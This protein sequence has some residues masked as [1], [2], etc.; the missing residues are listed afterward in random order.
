MENQLSQHNLSVKSPFPAW[1]VMSL[2]QKRL[3]VILC[4]LLVV[5]TWQDSWMLTLG[6]A[7][8]SAEWEQA[9]ATVQLTRAHLAAQ[10]S[11][12]E[13]NMS[14]SQHQ[15][16]FVALVL[17]LFSKQLC[18]PTIKFPHIKCTGW[19]LM[20]WQTCTLLDQT[21]QPNNTEHVHLSRKFPWG[22][23]Q[24]TSPPLPPEATTIIW[25]H[26]CVA[27]W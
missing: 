27:H 16:I 4:I 8:M 13:M 2:C 18:L 12:P 1:L 10:N 7:E 6:A 15:L 26:T 23:L 3:S 17:M 25:N 20:T 24:S 11:E 21:H 9:Y 14:G 19:W 22:S 5:G